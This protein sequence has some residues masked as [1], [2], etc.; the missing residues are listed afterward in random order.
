M[1][2]LI[3]SLVI[4][5]A[6][7][8]A[9]AFLGPAAVQKIRE[10]MPKP[11]PAEVRLEKPTVDDLVEVVRAKGVIEPK[12]KVEISARTSARIVELPFKEGDRVTKGDPNAN[13]PVEPS[14]LVRLDDSDLR[15]ALDA[16][17]A[18]RAADAASIDVQKAGLLQQ[19]AQIASIQADLTEAARNLERQTGLLATRDVAQ[20]VVDTAQARVDQ[21]KAQL[22]AAQQ[23]FSG[24][25]LQL[26]VMQ[27]NLE[28]AD[29]QIAQAREELSYTTIHSPIDG[30]LTRLNAEVGELVVTGTMNNA[31]TVILE[32]ADLNTMLF[33]AQV[34]ETDVGKLDI[35]QHATVRINA[36]PDEVFTGVVDTI[37]LQDTTSA[38]G[39][40][41]YKAEVLLDTKGRRILSGLTADVEIETR[42]HTEV[43]QVPS[44]C[45]VARKVDELPS[46]IR[47]LPEVALDKT[48]TTVV[49]R[50]MGD[51][52]VVTPVITGASSLTHTIITSGLAVDDIVITGPYKVL[53][54]IKNED[55]VKDEK[56]AQAER[57][58]KE[59]KA[60]A[61]QKASEEASA[62]A[63]G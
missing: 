53:E 4:V 3:V 23:S 28:A 34:D 13:P 30:I 35:G 42:R 54:G 29:A 60:K 7:L 26:V 40:K 33:I 12:T 19:K 32:V 46:D 55:P 41:Y 61:A 22:E 39:N 18:R 63:G 48:F 24:Q 16:T 21:L 20:S 47:D 11:P 52:A 37:A 50:L 9:A 31:G 59:D 45:V 49:Y 51:K 36:Y 1:N 44:Q 43:M 56:V 57:Q 25:E 58:A 15:A 38:D 14:V 2:K 10:S 5:V 8:G 17:E 6:L 27:H 62:P